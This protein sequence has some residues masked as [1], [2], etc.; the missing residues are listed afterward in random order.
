MP[1]TENKPLG[2][3][4]GNFVEFTE[5]ASC[6]HPTGQITVYVINSVDDSALRVR[7]YIGLNATTNTR[8]ML[9]LNDPMRAAGAF[10]IPWAPY[11]RVITW[12]PAAGGTNSV[13]LAY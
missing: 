3:V 2:N 11:I 10:R 4:G 5:Q 8:T 1:L 7:V 6:E 12:T 9:D 13:A